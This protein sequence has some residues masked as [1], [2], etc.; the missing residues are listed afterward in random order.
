MIG[1]TIIGLMLALV[2]L[3]GSAA[4]AQ[5]GNVA[6]GFSLSAGAYR[7]T[8]SSARD[9]LGST[10]LDIRLGYKMGENE[11]ADQEVAIGW[12]GAEGETIGGVDTD[13]RMIPLTYSYRTRPKADSKFYYGAGIGAYFTKVENINGAGVV[14]S[15]VDESKT[16][17]G[18]QGLVGFMVSDKISVE[19]GYTAIMGKVQDQNLSGFSLSLR[20]T[21]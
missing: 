5:D 6:K 16:K 8:Q 20:G 10:W 9:N 17:A 1:K 11:M 7:P 4:V 3:A 21:F 13:A 15:G 12:I 18:L 19:A 14:T 2:V